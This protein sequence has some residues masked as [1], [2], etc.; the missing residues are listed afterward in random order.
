MS[1][2]DRIEQAAQLVTSARAAVRAALAELLKQHEAGD[3]DLTDPSAQGTETQRFFRLGMAAD[4]LCGAQDELR[5][6]AAIGGE[7]KS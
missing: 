2:A 5:K 7:V 1:A 3:I 4:Q 6:A